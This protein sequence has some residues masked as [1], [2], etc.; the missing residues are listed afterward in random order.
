MFKQASRRLGR[1]LVPAIAIVLTVGL[2][3]PSAEATFY[4]R[5]NS[6]AWTDSRVGVS[7]KITAT[8]AYQ[9]DWGVVWATN[10]WN[11]PY[12]KT[13]RTSGKTATKASESIVL[14]LKGVGISVS[15][16]SSKSVGVGFSKSSNSCTGYWESGKKQS[17]I[18]VSGN[19]KVCNGKSLVSVT[20]GSFTTT[21]SL[22]VDNKTWS[23]TTLTI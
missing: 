6:K 21:G 12:A 14:T 23:Y 7:G 22:Q 3:A 18:A 8:G 4:P 9:A 20:G 19:G 1:I 2:A 15:V 16:S 17:S 10:S 11:S 13:W 5:S